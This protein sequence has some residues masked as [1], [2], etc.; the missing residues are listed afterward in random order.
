MRTFLLSL[1]ISAAGSAAGIPYMTQPALCPTRPEIAFVSGGD[2]WVAPAKGGEA[3]LLVSHPADDSRPLYSPDGTKL[4]FVSTRTG[5]GDIYVL[6]LANGEL[7][8]LTFD[9]RM[10][11]L[12]AWSRDGKWIYFSSGAHDVGGKNDLYR[13]SVEG[14]TPLAVSADRFT[15]EFQAAPSPDGLTLAFAARG[16]SD[17]QWWRHGHSHLD[18]SEIWLRKDGGTYERVIDLNGKNVWPMWMP[19]TRQFY[20]MSDRGGT[21]NIWTHTLGGK[22]R[23][24]TKFTDGRVLWPSIGYDGKAVVFERDFKIWQLDTKNGEAYALPITLVGSAASPGMQHLTLS[25]F[26]DLALSP[27]AKKIALIAHGEIFA[28]S[29]RDGGDAIRVTNTAGPESAV[30]WSP[31]STRIAYLSQRDAIT[32]VF[33]Y[34]FT[35]RAETQWTRDAASDQ[36]PH[37]SP[38]GK[39]IAFLRDRKELRIIDLDSKQERALATG[40]IGSGFGSASFSWSPDSKWV[41]YANSGAE[42][43]RNLFVVPVS[44]GAGR[45]ITFLANTNVN[46]IQW[47]PDGKYVLYNTSQRTETPQVARVDLTPRLPNFTEEKFEDLFKPEPPRAGRGGNADAKPPVKPVE[48]DFEDI[49]SRITM[50][51]IG[52]NVAQPQISP[53]G[54]SLLFSANVG[55]QTNLY[56]YPLDASPAGGRGGRGGGE[57]R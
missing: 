34:D 7:K 56:L 10:D 55:G 30:V 29:A 15:N 5:G 39:M 28:A 20:F 32:H 24:V 47:G 8:R 21:E 38:D 9:D 33:T 27:D 25:Q 42:S 54:K 22:P 50:L 6:T 35:K 46:G 1:S 36:S 41:A 3:H 16:V 40:F 31:D 13:V 51:P 44:G 11:Q 14:G 49:K 19:D 18:E 17:Q 53:D 45:E 57:A 43:L 48:I 4:A 12:D 26:T 2:I 37:F 23:Q 52:L